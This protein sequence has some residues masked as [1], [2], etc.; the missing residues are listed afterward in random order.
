MFWILC[1][2]VLSLRGD[3]SRDEEWDVMVDL[4][5]HR[6]FDDKKEKQVED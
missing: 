3:I 6:E 5:M 4:F 1:K 2:E